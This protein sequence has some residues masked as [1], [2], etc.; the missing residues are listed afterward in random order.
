M[1]CAQSRDEQRKEQVSGDFRFVHAFFRAAADKSVDAFFPVD[2]LAGDYLGKDKEINEGPL[3][4]FKD[5]AFK[6]LEELQ[7]VVAGI[8]DSLKGDY[9]KH[10]AVGEADD[11]E[12][13][14]FG[15]YQS[16]DVVA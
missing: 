8:F 3:G 9:K 13:S 16:K 2:K 4:E 1:G 12:N 15:K 10:K 5:D 6:N 14:V 11:K 7:K